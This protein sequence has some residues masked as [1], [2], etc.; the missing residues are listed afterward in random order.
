[1]SREEMIEY[2]EDCCVGKNCSKCRLENHLDCEFEQYNAKELQ[3][4]IDILNNNIIEFTKQ[5]LFDALKD[6]EIGEDY[7]KEYYIKNLQETLDKLF[8]KE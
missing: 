2:L 1:M 6:I 7:Y 4:A 5:E 3:K 8:D